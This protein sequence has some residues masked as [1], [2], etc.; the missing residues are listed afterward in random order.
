MADTP[1]CVVSTQICCDRQQPSGKLAFEIKPASIVIHSDEGLLS[2][3]DRVRSVT[4]ISQDERKQRLLPA[5]HQ[6][7]QR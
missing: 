3:F 5:F 4:D 2:K 1:P 6:L 7:I